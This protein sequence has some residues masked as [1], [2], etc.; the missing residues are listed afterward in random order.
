MT[1]H[2][3]CTSPTN[4]FTSS[5]PS[6]YTDTDTLIDFEV[7][8]H[9]PE[10]H[11][12]ASVSFSHQ[13]P[14]RY[15]E[16]FNSSPPFF[17][18]LENKALPPTRTPP[19]P[20]KPA[21]LYKSPNMEKHSRHHTTGEESLTTTAHH[22]HFI[23]APLPSLPLTYQSHLPPNTTTMNNKTDSVWQALCVRVLPLF[24][25]EG[26]QGAVEDMNDLLRQCLSDPISPQLVY[27]I[28]TLLHDGMFTLNT[29]LFGVTD[30]KLLDRLVEQWSFFFTYALPYFEAVFLPLRTDY[31]W[32]NVR[33]M[34][35]QS[36]RDDVI[37]QQ[38]KRLEGVFN[39]L[40]TAEGF[41][42]N[43]VATAAK[44]IQMISLLA[45]APSSN[46]E[47]DRILAKLKI[48]IMRKGGSPTGMVNPWYGK[49]MIDNVLI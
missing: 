24:N 21:D 22:R 29:K 34:A 15:P 4:S 1:I 13:L 32:H 3:H 8:L 25:G 26:V 36:F 20:K 39:R 14:T 19:P 27:N 31:G 17:A 46:E 12:H 6:E 35:L 30:E 40:F 33:N 42:Q 2:A 28:E 23:N 47:M 11:T 16:T 5:P 48:I 41:S 37:L 7:T 9:S 45:S 38:T 49:K 43:P 44:M 10:T 18:P